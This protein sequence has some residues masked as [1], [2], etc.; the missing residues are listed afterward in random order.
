MM[1]SGRV[2]GVRVSKAGEGSSS[3][4]EEAVMVCDVVVLAT[5]GFAANKTLLQVTR[6]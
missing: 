3:D 6:G 5:G 1:D 4:E 2:T